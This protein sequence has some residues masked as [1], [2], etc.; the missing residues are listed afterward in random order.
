MKNDEGEEKQKKKVR[1]LPI[2]LMKPLKNYSMMV[3]QI[4]KTIG[5]EEFRI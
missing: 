3:E 1:V 2:I 5:N 4:R